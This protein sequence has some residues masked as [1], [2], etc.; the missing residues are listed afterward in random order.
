M[1]S[2]EVIPD[3]LQFSKPILDLSVPVI[4][5]GHHATIAADSASVRPHPST[6]K[7]SASGELTNEMLR[8]MSVAMSNLTLMCQ[9]EESRDK[10]RNSFMDIENNDGNNIVHISVVQKEFSALKMIVDMLVKLKV[11]EVLDYQN[12]ECSTALHLAADTQQLS[13]VQLLVT[14]G[15]SCDV[16]DKDGDTPVHISVLNNDSSVLALLLQHQ[17]NTNLSN[18]FGKFPLHIAVEHN[19]LD[20]VS[21]LLKAGADVDAQDNITGKT[22][23]HLAM[24]R[25][26]EEMVLLLVKDGLADVGRADYSGVT[27]GDLADSCKSNSIKK[28]VSKEIKKQL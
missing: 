27:S 3:L 10:I 6:N 9:T 11:T 24:E 7:S 4:T 18:N 14:A 8:T 1:S 5:L 20:V 17:A 13:A 23:L 15:A 28:I 12:K 26:L 16:S 2:S 25:N 19:L 21:L 22:P